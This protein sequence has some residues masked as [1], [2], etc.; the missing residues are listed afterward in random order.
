MVC[1][2]R[3]YCNWKHKT[4]SWRDTE[5]ILS[6]IAT[7]RLRALRPA[8]SLNIACPIKTEFIRKVK[9]ALLKERVTQI[10]DKIKYLIKGIE[11]RDVELSKL[12]PLYTNEAAMIVK[13]T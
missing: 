10:V 9:K 12:L 1:Q 4:K 13:V 2:C 11:T 3:K 5:T 7:V 8:T 6:S